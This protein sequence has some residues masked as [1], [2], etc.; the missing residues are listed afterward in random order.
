MP[1]EIALSDRRAKA[2][3]FR[4]IAPGGAAVVNADD[5]HAEILGAVNLDARRVSFGMANPTQ[6]DISGRIERLDATGS[7]FV[8]HGF[9]RSTTVDLRLYGPRQVSHAVAAAALAWALEIDLDAVVAGLEGVANVAG[10][11]E[12][13]DEG[14][15]SMSG[16][17]RPAPPRRSTRP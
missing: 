17:M 3:L 6:V 12:A 10:H 8:L 11:L 5:P 9:D 7:R 16:S 4:R 14:R 15:I 13:V 2:K 1:I